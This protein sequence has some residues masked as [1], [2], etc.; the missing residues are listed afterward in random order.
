[1]PKIICKIAGIV[2]A[3]PSSGGFYLHSSAVELDGRAYLFSG[4]SGVGKSTHTRLWQQIFGDGCRFATHKNGFCYAMS[5]RDEFMFV[6]SHFVKHYRDS[7]IGCRHVT[8]LWV[9]AC[10]MMTAE[11]IFQ[12]SLKSFILTVFTKI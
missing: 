8:D 12:A 9:L 5:E 11:S 3:V 6:F 7:G 4:K 10:S 1:M 2:T